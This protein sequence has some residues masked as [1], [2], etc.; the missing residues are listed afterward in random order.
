M[1]GIEWNGSCKQQ[2][3]RRMN[4]NK[5][6]DGLLP[7]LFQLSPSSWLPTHSKRI[8]ISQTPTPS[9][10]ACIISI[11]LFD[12][13][14]RLAHAISRSLIG[15]Q[16]LQTPTASLV[17]LPAWPSTSLDP[18]LGALSAPGGIELSAPTHPPPSGLP[19]SCSASY[20]SSRL[21]AGA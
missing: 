6:N 9:I 10:P 1:Q 7:F 15:A 3:A 13:T 21:G 8:S 14:L 20:E 19:L 11:P 2:A 17:G 12:N 5:A 4:T 18:M 16:D